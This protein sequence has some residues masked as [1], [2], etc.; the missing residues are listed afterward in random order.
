MGDISMPGQKGSESLCACK[1]NT[2]PQRCWKA[3]VNRSGNSQSI[4]AEGLVVSGHQIV[5]RLLPA[6]VALWIMYF[7]D[8][9]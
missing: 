5:S 6:S 8:G 1:K 2:M 4:Y 3:C 9:G 7:R